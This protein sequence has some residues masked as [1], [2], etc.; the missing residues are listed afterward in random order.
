M[1]IFGFLLACLGIFFF[2]VALASYLG[3]AALV[4]MW[5][6]RRQEKKRQRE[7]MWK[8]WPHEPFPVRRW[9]LVVAA[10]PLSLLACYGCIVWGTER[11]Y[12]VPHEVQQQA[13]GVS[14]TG[15]SA[16]NVV[17][18]VRI[19]NSNEFPVS[20]QYREVRNAYPDM[21]RVAYVETVWVKVLNPG[22]EV[23]TLIPGCGGT[24]RI[25]NQNGMEIGVI[26]DAFLP[27]PTTPKE[28]KS[29]NS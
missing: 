16:T 26:L 14:I 9:Y 5:L 11:E 18:R 23:E 19:V 29:D 13:A 24:L 7:S 8:V 4:I 21:R 15:E 2:G 3:C 10:L 28:E 25:S 22:Q 6:Q 27:V 20:L 17:D 12:R 1:D